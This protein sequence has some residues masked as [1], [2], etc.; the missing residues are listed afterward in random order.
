MKVLII[1]DEKAASRNLRSLINEIDPTIIIVDMLD[2]VVGSVEWLNANAHPDLIFMDIHL[3]DGSA[4]DIFDRCKVDSPV[5]FT[6]AYDEYALKAF[7]V[8]SIDY[9]LKPISLDDLRA[10]IEKFTKLQQ[11]NVAVNSAAIDS[12][13]RAIHSRNNTTHLLI[14]QYGDKIF[15]LDISTVAF[16][17]IDNGI[18]RATTIDG[19]VY[20]VPHTLDQLMEMID[21]RRFFRANRQYIVSKGAVEQIELWYGGRL[22]VRLRFCIGE[23]VLINKPR[24]GEFKAWLSGFGD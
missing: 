13:I 22:S 17:S 8:N 15:P 14:P 21:G 10:S 7:K 24:V 23:K 1:E 3:A 11:K 2:T 5:I 12:L 9:L 16:F 19:S 18:V 6:T 20:N 4:F